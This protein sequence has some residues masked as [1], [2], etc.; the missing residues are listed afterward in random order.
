[1]GVPGQSEGGGL[2]GL[3]LPQKTSTVGPAG[4]P[5]LAHC[6][7][8]CLPFPTQFLPLGSCS[9]VTMPT[10]LPPSSCTAPGSS[11]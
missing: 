10:D 11:L 8:P 3:Q 4:E 6:P 9:L 2:R 5:V 1:M 7:A